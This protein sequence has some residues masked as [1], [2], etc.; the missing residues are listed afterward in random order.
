[1]AN[2]GS[3]TI[4]SQHSNA[5]VTVTNTAELNAAIANLASSGGGTILVDANG[6]PYNLSAYGVGSANSPVL[7]KALDPTNLPTFHQISINNSSYISISGIHVDNSNVPYTPTYQSDLQISGSNHIEFVD[8]MMTS[9]A[10]GFL[11]NANDPNGGGN[12]AL[13][14]NSQDI[15]FSNNFVS[16]YMRG[17]TFL[18]VKGLIFSGNEFTG[19]QYDGFQ[20]GGLQ[21]AVI[22]NNYMHDFYG[23]TQTAN[24]SD[25]MMIWGTNAQSVTT[26]VQINGNILDTGNGAAYQGIF[27]GN[28]SLGQSGPAG[29]YF[30]DIRV[31]DNVVH[32][33]MWHGISVYDTNQLQ[34][35][36]NTVLWD[37]DAY[38]KSS[39]NSGWTQAQ[40]WIK[41][42]NT[43]GAQVLGNVAG[44]IDVAGVNASNVASQNFI[45]DYNDPTSPNYYANHI[46]HLDA[47]GSN[48]SDLQFLPSSPLYGAFGSSISSFGSSISSG[49]VGS[50]S[51]ATGTGGTTPPLTGGSSTSGIGSMD[52]TVGGSSS[53]T[54]SGADAATQSSVVQSNTS[55][56]TSNGDSG[57][58]TGHVATNDSVTDPQLQHEATQVSG[59]I[60]KSVGSL[61]AKIGGSVAQAANSSTG[62]GAASNASA[63]VLNGATIH[64][65]VSLLSAEAQ[66][67]LNAVATD[68]DATAIDPIAIA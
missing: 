5:T 25:F 34:L 12:I 38:T 51:S 32:T 13:V 20:A 42:A 36:D 11:V 64:D 40:P 35:Y 57:Q 61:I 49:I 28:N 27:I 2:A 39:P 24:H 31:Y 68:T 29:Q 23:S 21:N 44:R 67:D 52:P 33:A 7:I 10:H 3:Y 22:S 63:T 48:V 62:V 17:A 4:Y 45:L 65:L 15:V 9:M 43:P 56:D 66:A 16:D 46:A 59:L 54:S 58:S 1:M 14:R 37:M 60:T 50:G 6:G 41:A 53:G 26:N 18:E 19:I 55:S 30:Q 47:G 8:S